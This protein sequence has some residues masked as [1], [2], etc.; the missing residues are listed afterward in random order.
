MTPGEM[1]DM[2]APDQGVAQLPRITAAEPGAASSM[3]RSGL[4]KRRPAAHIQRMAKNAVRLLEVKV[5]S[6]R[7][8]YW[9]WQVCDSDTALVVGY[10]TSRETAQFDGDNALFIELGKP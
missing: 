9:E 4:A 2:R 8:D 3:K 5:I 7:P 6:L 1:F 10:A